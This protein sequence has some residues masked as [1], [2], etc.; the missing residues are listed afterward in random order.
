MAENQPPSL[1][2]LRTIDHPGA[3]GEAATLEQAEAIRQAPGADLP[4]I[5][6][7]AIT[8]EIARGGMGCVYSGRDLILGR[9]VAIKA[10]LPGA[11]PERFVTEAKITARLPHPGIPPVY[12]IGALAD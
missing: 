2:P 7:Y 6:G 5:P 1:D 4:S 3:A 11:N 8:G 10:L 9:E 12:A